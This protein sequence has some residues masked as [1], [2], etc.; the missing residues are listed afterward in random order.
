MGP[1]NHWEL[2][3]EGTLAG[4]RGKTYYVPHDE[5][6]YHA[7]HIVFYFQVRDR[8][9]AASLHAHDQSGWDERDLNL[10]RRLIRSLRPANKL[11]LAMGRSWGRS[12]LVGKPLPIF[13]LSDAV[14]GGGAVWAESYATSK[15]FRIAAGA[16]AVDKVARVPPNPYRGMLLQDGKLWVSSSGAARVVALDIRTGKTLHTVGT[17]R[18]PQDLTM[19]EGMLWVLNVRDATI[20]RINPV[21][22]ETLGPPLKIPGEPVAVDSLGGHLWV[23]DCA[24]GLLL[25]ISPDS[26]ELLA[27]VEVGSGANDVEAFD[28]SLWI[29]DWSAGKVVRVDSTTARVMAVI[30]AGDTPGRLAGRSGSLWVADPRGR[31]VLRIDSATNRVVEILRVGDSPS[32]VVV[33]NQ[34]V[35][36]LDAH[37]LI[38]VRLALAKD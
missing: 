32:G 21:T 7:G 28:G 1:Q 34:I 10:L 5:M 6:A 12:R 22:A 19:L 11:P 23:V 27:S 25:K 9:Y 30:P 8:L 14:M 17:G 29:S 4:H 26:G 13:E 37:R 15:I 16:G 36:I 35:W 20:S 38:R 31:Q 24:G 18:G 2:I 33:G 3:G